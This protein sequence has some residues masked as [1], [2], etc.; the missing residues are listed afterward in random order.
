MFKKILL[1]TAI[2]T[3]LS[4]ACYAQGAP[5]N[6]PIYQ[7]YFTSGVNAY[8]KAAN[9]DCKNVDVD[10]TIEYL[11]KLVGKIQTW[12]FEAEL[13]QADGPSSD[14]YVNARLEALSADIVLANNEVAQL[15]DAIKNL[16][17]KPPCKPSSKKTS[18][19]PAS[20]PCSTCCAAYY[21]AR[22][23]SPPTSTCPCPSS[24]GSALA[25]A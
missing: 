24:S 2:A 10:N 16:N 25:V 9:E 1:G 7:D 4:T 12:A 5:G 6:H 15:Q 17:A 23:P 19:P 13:L 20:P 11:Q 3:V 14:R 21:P 22:E 8:R 18:K